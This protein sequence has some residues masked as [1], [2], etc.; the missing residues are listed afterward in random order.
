LDGYRIIRELHASKRT[1]IYLALDTET[2]AQVILKTPS[3]NYQDDPGYIDRFL[4]EEWV[5]RRLRSPHTLSV[6]A[7][8][9]RRQF[10]YYVTEHVE[11]VTLR[12]W[13][14]TH[15]HP[16][17]SEVRAI[18]EQ[19]A[20]GL[21]AFHRL[22]ML[23]QDLK[24]ENILIDPQGTV[25]IIDFGSTKIAGIE[26]V[27]NPLPR[28]DMLGT[29]NYIAPEYLQGYAGTNR[30]DIYSLG[31][32][33]YEMLTGAL[34]YGPESSE[35]K[36]SRLRYTPIVQHNPDVPAWVDGAVAK[37][38][39]I[40]PQQRYTTLSEFVHDLTHPNHALTPQSPLPLIE[41]NPIAFWRGLA[42]ALF[43]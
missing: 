16:A 24:P 2:Q 14:Q 9:R 18:V 37:A 29:R 13:M 20:T 21:R 25:K 42:I 10:L 32:I 1:Q 6:P 36:L 4:H 33:A 23:H 22:E 26:E 40:D 28:D 31:V 5:G 43:F 12:L 19:I 27:A 8:V 3:V 35:K 30:S 34:P 11:G 38:V 17:L 39:A 7:A 15:P 41:R